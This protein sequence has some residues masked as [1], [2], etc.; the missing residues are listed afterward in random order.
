MTTATAQRRTAKKA[1]PPLPKDP[2]KFAGRFLSLLSVD[3][4]TCTFGVIGSP[5]M[6]VITRTDWAKFGRAE[7]VWIHVQVAE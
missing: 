2:E 6:L 4:S 3:E 7:R 5:E 1:A